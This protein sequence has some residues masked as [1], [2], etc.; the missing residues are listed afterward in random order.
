MFKTIARYLTAINDQQA[1]DKRI[2]GLTA[3]E[4]E[5]DIKRALLGDAEDTE[6]QILSHAEQIK[7]LRALVIQKIANNESATEAIA[8]LELFANKPP[9]PIKHDH[10]FSIP[11][12]SEV[13]DILRMATIAG[14][15]I[16]GAMLV[17]VGVNPRFCGSSNDSQFCNQVDAAYRYFYNPKEQN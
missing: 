5:V 14:L 3:Y 4:K 12:L 7:L 2:K 13:A 9:H 10:L 11:V 16:G 1:I 17:T 6:L 8:A 15:I